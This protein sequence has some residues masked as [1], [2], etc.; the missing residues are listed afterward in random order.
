MVN[1]TMQREHILS[2]QMI[3]RL[4]AP[5]VEE[6]LKALILLYLVRRPSFTYFVDG[7]IYGFAAGMGFAV[8]ENYQYILGSNVPG[9]SV[10]IGRVL[11]TNLIHA[12]ASA[13]VGIAFGYSR[14]QRSWK[15]VLYILAGFWPRPS[16]TRSTTTWSAR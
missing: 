6:T 4:G 13:L 12:S 10:A 9:I 16:C 5:I 3:I 14:F 8:F 11:S 15:K 2:T 7:A 1:R